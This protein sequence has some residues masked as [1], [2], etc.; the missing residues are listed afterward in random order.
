MTN[1]TRRYNVNHA[2]VAVLLDQ[3][4]QAERGEVT[5][6]R[7]ARRLRVSAAVL[8]AAVARYPE[9]FQT[10]VNVG[11][12]AVRTGYFVQRTGVASR[13]HREAVVSLTAWSR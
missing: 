12:K 3:M 1:E 13:R 5:V 7:A 2:F 6:T 4:L 9:T 11:W 8:R 10:R